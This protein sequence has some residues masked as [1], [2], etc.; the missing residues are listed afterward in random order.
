ML[1]EH[2]L[3]IDIGDDGRI[4]LQGADIDLVRSARR[5]DRA[6]FLIADQIDGIADGRIVGDTALKFLSFRSAEDFTKQV[7]RRAGDVIVGG[8]QIL[9]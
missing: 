1:G 8:R 7:D 2:F 6:E 3:D 9:A 5:I 4:L